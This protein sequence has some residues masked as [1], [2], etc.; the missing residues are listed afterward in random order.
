MNRKLPFDFTTAYREYMAAI[1]FQTRSA[2][3]WDMRAPSMNQHSTTV[4]RYSTAF[5]AQVQSNSSD[6]VLD[7]GCGSGTLALKI[8]PSVKQVFCLDHSQAMLDCLTE[9]AQ[10]QGIRNITTLHL[11]KEESW[12]DKVPL[13]D[14]V[15]CSRAGVDGDLEQLFVKL[16]NHARRAVYFSHLVGGHFD[17]V[18]ISALLQQT[19]AP[20]PDYI[21]AVNILYQLGFDPNLSFVTTHGRLQDCT[22]EADFLQRMQYQYKQLS[23]GDQSKLQTFYRQNH[24]LFDT[25]RFGMKWALLNWEVQ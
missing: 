20:F 8:A 2:A 19:R 18:A 6:T 11:S 24:K 22:S 23:P 10:Q 5:L 13:C 4:S 12:A 3:E 17:C 9:N 25:E 16:S 14:L 15:I 7:V 21:Y 1:R